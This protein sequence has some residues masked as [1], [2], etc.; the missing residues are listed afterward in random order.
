MAWNVNFTPRAVKAFRKLDKPIQR[1]ITEFLRD[2]SDISDPRL[3]G[4]TLVGNKSGLWRWRV[5]DYR[6]IADIHDENLTIIVVDTGH[7]KDIYD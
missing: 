7:R 6:I 3:R 5:E 1:R 4:K 2:V